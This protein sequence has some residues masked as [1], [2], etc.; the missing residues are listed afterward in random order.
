MPKKKDLPRLTGLDAVEAPTC[1]LLILGSMPGRESLLRQQYYAH[2]RNQF[3]P[4]MTTLLG[5]EPKA[6][7]PERLN[8]LK[9]NR[10]SLWDVIGACIR[11]GSLDGDIDPH[12]EVPNPLPA[13]IN[14]HPELKALAFNGRKAESSFKR[15]FLKPDPALCH[16]LELID[17]PSTS[18]AYA[19]LKADVKLALWREKLAPFLPTICNPRGDRL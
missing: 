8:L 9:N 15:H 1:R 10:I 6:P 18:P 13:L 14:R 3:W 12:S 19:G 5:G 2:P 17:L 16:D 11:P 7:Y 4:I